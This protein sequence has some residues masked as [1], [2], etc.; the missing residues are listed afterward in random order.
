MNGLGFLTNPSWVL[1]N[2]VHSAY[3]INLPYLG[4]LSVRVVTFKKLMAKISDFYSIALQMNGL[5][6]DTKNILV[7]YDWSPSVTICTVLL[8]TTN[9][10][11]YVAM[12]MFLDML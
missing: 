6:F 9:P 1:D 7:F 8:M 11:P 10:P 12:E 4:T 3:I 5:H 2:Y